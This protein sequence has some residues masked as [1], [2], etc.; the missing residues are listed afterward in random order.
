MHRY[1]DKDVDW[2]G[3]DDAAYYIASFCRRYGRLGGQAKE[4]YGTVRFYPRFGA[5]SLFCITH[6]GYV[7]YWSTWAWYAKFDIAY[8][9]KIMRYSGL[10]NF[11][12]LW[13]PYVYGLAYRC[14]LKKWPHLRKEIL[15]CADYP[16]FI[17]EK[18]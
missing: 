5:Y 1:G 16:E 3:I 10:Q 4:K 9:N 7:S 8:G 2:R 14:A 17:E 15:A 6:P 12:S 18:Q 11:F 13:Q